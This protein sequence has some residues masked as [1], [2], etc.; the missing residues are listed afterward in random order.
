MLHWD[1]VVKQAGGHD[2][3]LRAQELVRCRL[4]LDFGN[5]H[6]DWEAVIVGHVDIATSQTRDDVRSIGQLDVKTLYATSARF[7]GEIGF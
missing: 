1:T 4:E 7:R 6:M 2:T 3:R 5:L